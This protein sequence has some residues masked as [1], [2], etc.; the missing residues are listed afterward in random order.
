MSSE[1]PWPDDDELC[2]CR[3]LTVTCHP[4]RRQPHSPSTLSHSPSAFLRPDAMNG[5]GLHTL[6][7]RHTEQNRTDTAPSCTA[8]SVEFAE[9]GGDG[10]GEEEMCMSSLLERTPHGHPL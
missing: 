10:N 7:A 3:I 6:L 5:G 4:I 2:S 8:H 9:G 1:I